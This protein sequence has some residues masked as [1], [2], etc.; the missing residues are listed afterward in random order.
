[1]AR[2]EERSGIHCNPHKLRH[3]FATPS[4]P[5]AS[6]RACRCSI[7]R[8]PSATARSTWCGGTTPRTGMRRRKASIARSGVQGWAGAADAGATH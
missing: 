3:T 8:T 6:T 5:G 1:M 7:S 2:L 4:P